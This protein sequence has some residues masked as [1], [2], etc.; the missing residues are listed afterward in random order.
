MPTPLRQPWAFPVS[1]DDL[2][3]DDFEDPT[4]LSAPLDLLPDATPP[5]GSQSWAPADDPAF[6]EPV[7][8]GEFR[9]Q[10]AGF[11]IGEN[12]LAELGITPAWT[13]E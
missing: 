7:P 12:P 11:G 8:E 5:E 13:E 4:D 3:G 2:G 1:P 6:P 9:P 10:V